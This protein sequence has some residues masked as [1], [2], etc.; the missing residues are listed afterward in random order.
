MEQLTIEDLKKVAKLLTVPLTT[1]RIRVIVTPFCHNFE[2][3]SPL[4]RDVPKT[5]E[6]T[7]YLRLISRKAEET[8]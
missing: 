1:E 5:V 2:I 4:T 8:K 7:S 6:P 3:L